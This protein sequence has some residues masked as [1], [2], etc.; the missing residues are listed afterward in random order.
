MLQLSGF[1]QVA[2]QEACDRPKEAAFF[3]GNKPA[4]RSKGCRVVALGSRGAYPERL[5]QSSRAALT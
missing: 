3:L 4:R 1:H 2:N 5:R